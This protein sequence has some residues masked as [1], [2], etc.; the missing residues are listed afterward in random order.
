MLSTWDDNTFAK[1]FDNKADTGVVS[2]HFAD[3]ATTYERQ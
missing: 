3:L 2:L 1:V